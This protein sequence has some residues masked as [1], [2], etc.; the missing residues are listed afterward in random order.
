VT[1]EVRAERIGQLLDLIA[2]RQPKDDMENTGE[3]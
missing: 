1:E 3:L 2:Q